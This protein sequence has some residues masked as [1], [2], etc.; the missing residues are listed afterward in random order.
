MEQEAATTAN[1]ARL[2]V[3]VPFRDRPQHTLRF[4]GWANSIR[5]P[6][7]IIFADGGD[8]EELAAVLSDPARFPHLQY[9]YLRQPGTTDVTGY[10]TR[11]LAAAE[12]ITTPYAVVNPND[13]FFLVSVL[14]QAVEF[15]DAHPDHA[16]VTGELVDF[17]AEHRPDLG[18]LN[19]VYGRIATPGKVFRARSYAQPAGLQRMADHVMN[20]FNNGPVYS[21]CRLDAFR[22]MH[23]L[24]RQ[25]DAPDWHFADR[26]LIF[27]LIACGKIKACGPIALHQADGNTAG[28]EMVTRDRTWLTWAQ[29]P[30]WPGIFNRLLDAVAALVREIDGL[31]EEEA[32]TGFRSVFYAAFGKQVL[33][34]FH[35]GLRQ[36]P[37]DIS[38]EELRILNALPD[39][40]SIVDYMVAG[41]RQAEQRV[42]QQHGGGKTMT[43]TA[44]GR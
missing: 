28:M 7:P 3:V 9:T 37:A 40:R 10:M 42:R 35:P 16:A 23:A 34:A 25:V 26:A 4:A 43:T 11:V 1:P 17:H 32:R 2:T 36:A 33:E 19:T 18:A 12:R 5:Y 24:A 30:E 41:L 38:A 14:R 21:V 27:A 20:M 31:G 6:F 13:D 29:R 39:T 44:G 8:N 22:R 15:L